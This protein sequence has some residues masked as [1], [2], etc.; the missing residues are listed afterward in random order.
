MTPDERA[1]RDRLRRLLGTGAGQAVIDAAIDDDLRLVLAALGRYETVEKSVQ[2]TAR[3][4]AD[5]AGLFGPVPDRVEV[6]YNRA[7]TWAGNVKA[8]ATGVT[9]G[10]SDG[11]TLVA[12]HARARDLA[13]D[14][15][16]AIDAVEAEAEAR[17]EGWT[18]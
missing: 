10:L 2:E 5:A 8:S 9:I 11:D 12:T 18:G 4:V 14:I 15:T 16:E 13:S 6:T 17:A 7:H 3:Q 1:A